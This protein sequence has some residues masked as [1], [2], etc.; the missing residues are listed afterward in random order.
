MDTWALHCCG[1]LC[2]TTRV[3]GIEGGGS[4]SAHNRAM[5]QQR[6]N[7]LVVP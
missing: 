2:T 7:E 3:Q 5:A 4:A 1:A 6:A